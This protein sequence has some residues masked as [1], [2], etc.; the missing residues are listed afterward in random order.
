MRVAEN[1]PKIVWILKRCGVL[2]NIEYTI[3]MLILKY[4]ESMQNNRGILKTVEREIQ[5]C[6]YNRR[7][8][9]PLVRRTTNSL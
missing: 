6:K 5:R 9:S 3:D 2:L 1:G 7:P 4:K 8:Q